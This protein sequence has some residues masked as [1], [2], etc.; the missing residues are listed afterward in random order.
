[1]EN[2]GLY[3]FR[4]FDIINGWDIQKESHAPKNQ[5][6]G[7]EKRWLGSGKR[8][9]LLLNTSNISLIARLLK[10]SLVI[11]IKVSLTIIRDF[12][13]GMVVSGRKR[14]KLKPVESQ[15]NVDLF[16]HTHEEKIIR[17]GKVESLHETLVLLSI[18]DG[19]NRCLREMITRVSYVLREVAIWKLTTLKDGLHT[20]IYGMKLVTAGRYAF[21]ATK[22]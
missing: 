21:R 7:L 3:G 11:Y 9:V 12:K 1:M 14:L 16:H 17:I 5:S 10:R 20:S 19:V 2:K 6:K 13:K 4:D 8:A 15:K 18:K 22:L